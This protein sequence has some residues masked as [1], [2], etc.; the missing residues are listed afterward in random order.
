MRG[1]FVGEEDR[2]IVRERTRDRDPLLLAARHVTRPVV[3]AV[4]EIDPLAAARSARA[5]ASLRGTPAARSGTITFSTAVSDGT[6]LNAWNT[7]PTVLRR[8]SV[9]AAPLSPTTS[10][11]AD[12]HRARRRREDRREHRQQRG[13]AAAARAEQQHELARAGVE[14]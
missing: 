7:T 2:R 11:P 14:R 12:A 13:L 3:Q 4:A 6:R 9:S 1:R 5:L 10:V 8:Y